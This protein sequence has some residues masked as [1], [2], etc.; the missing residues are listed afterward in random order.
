[1]TLY[2]RGVD[3]SGPETWQL[4][5]NRHAATHVILDIGSDLTNIFLSETINNIEQQIVTAQESESAPSYDKKDLWYGKTGI[6]IGEYFVLS[7]EIFYEGDQPRET[8]SWLSL[9]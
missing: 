1:M 5:L 3:H 8:D 2:W 9:F 6:I 7:C 4:C